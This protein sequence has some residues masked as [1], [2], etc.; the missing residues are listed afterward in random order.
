MND[1]VLQYFESLP[2]GEEPAIITMHARES[3]PLKVIMPIV[4][5][6]QQAEAVVDSGSQI[7]SMDGTIAKEL[8]LEWDPKIVIHMQSAN[9]GLERTLGL[10]R[11][12][13]FMFG[14]VTAYL[15]VHVLRSAPYQVLLGRPFDVL[16]ES[17][18]KNHSDGSQD[19]TV[20]DPVS[21]V[22]CK[23]KT[24]DKSPPKVSKPPE[25]SYAGFR[26]SRI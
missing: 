16:M 5:G 4:N 25:S 22:R 20:I 6:C 17:E 23:L 19:I 24:L 13:P 12:V 18:V 1:P 9:G 7:V 8:G 26:K 3:Q 15:Q 11:N 10:A 2:E 21:K 14:K